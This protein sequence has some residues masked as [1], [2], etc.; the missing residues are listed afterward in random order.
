MTYTVTRIL[1]RFERKLEGPKNY[2]IIG[3][4][5][6]VEIPKEMKR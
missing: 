1:R 6:Q 5:A 2:T 3:Q 4:S